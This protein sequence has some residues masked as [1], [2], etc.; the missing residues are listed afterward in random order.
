[1]LDGHAVAVPTWDI[2]GVLPFEGVVLDDDVFEDL[3]EGVAHVD[4]AVGE[5][6]SIV[7][8]ILT[9]SSLGETLLIE[10]LALP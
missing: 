1:M 8:Y 5:G 6:R 10:A 2:G 4:V 9:G 7:Q 3:V